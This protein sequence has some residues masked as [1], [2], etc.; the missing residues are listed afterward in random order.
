MSDLEGMGLAWGIGALVLAVSAVAARRIPL[1]QAAR[2]A[3]AW[4]AVF[5][6]GLAIA[7]QRDRLGA[8]W[9]DMS[10]DLFGRSQS[11]AGGTLRIPMAD[12]GH[13]W[14]DA[15]IN[16]HATRML[17]DSGAT[18]TSLSSEAARAAGVDTSAGLV[19]GL[20]TANGDIMAQ[21]GRAQTLRIGSIVAHDL[22]VVTADAFGD[23]SVIGMNFLSRL[24]SW[25]VEGRTLILTPRS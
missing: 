9:A 4:I 2:M 6:V 13:F 24:E 17:V 25:R 14:V 23:T 20:S 3:F 7:S 22:P 5:A 16:G 18:T 11:I 15:Q 10:G 12:D 8:L 1:G 21:L 19:T